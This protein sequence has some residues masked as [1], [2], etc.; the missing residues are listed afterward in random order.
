M[1]NDSS[2]IR[3]AKELEASGFAVSVASPTVFELYAGVAMS[4]KPEK[5]RS[6]IMSVVA[7]LPQLPLDFQSA[8]EG[9][10]IYSAKIK[11]GSRI[12]P[13]DAM[14]A[15]IAKTKAEPIITRNIKHFSGIEGVTIESY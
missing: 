13:E 12:D 3:K 6:K 11:A 2:A 15:G 9:G 1:A 5:E 7:S 10:L 14:L 4:R 8:R